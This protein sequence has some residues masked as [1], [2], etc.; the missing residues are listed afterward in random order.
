MVDVPE[1]RSEAELFSSTPCADGENRL[2]TA[3]IVGRGPTI[4]PL[5]TRLMLTC[6]L[7]FNLRHTRGAQ[8]RSTVR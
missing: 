5:T 4:V 6:C 3:P 7:I 8:D 2:E 1:D